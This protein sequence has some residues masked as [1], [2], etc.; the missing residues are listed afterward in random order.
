MIFNLLIIHNDDRMSSITRV[1]HTTTWNYFTSCLP[2]RFVRSPKVLKE[3]IMADI[4]DLVQEFWRY[5]SDGSVV[6]G[7][8][9]FAMR[10]LFENMEEYF[11]ILEVSF[12]IISISRLP[13]TWLIKIYSRI[14][15]TLPLS[16]TLT[17]SNSEPDLRYYLMSIERC[18]ISR[19]LNPKIWVTC[20]GSYL[21]S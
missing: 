4:N 20:S 2:N 7:V 14:P 19:F 1:L 3:A 9:F 18:L 13:L 6:S 17:K 11:V 15:G 8:S 10:L 5:S 21:V 12:D 16:R